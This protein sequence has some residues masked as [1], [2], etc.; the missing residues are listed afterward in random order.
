MISSHSEMKRAYCNISIAFHVI[1]Y[2]ERYLFVSLSY[3]GL[4]KSKPNSILYMYLFIFYDNNKRNF[5][6]CGET[7]YQLAEHG[8]G[9]WMYYSCIIN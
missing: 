9:V 8:N 2:R 5:K 6:T 7:Q 4:L 1:L 3:N